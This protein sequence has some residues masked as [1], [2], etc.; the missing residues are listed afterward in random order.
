[1]TSPFLFR[2][3]VR[4]SLCPATRWGRSRVSVAGRMQRV[5][6][7]GLAQPQEW[8]LS[9]GARPPVCLQP[10]LPL[11]PPALPLAAQRRGRRRLAPRGRSGSRHHT[12][13]CRV[14]H[15]PNWRLATRRH[16]HELRRARQC[17]RPLTSRRGPRGPRRTTL[18]SLRLRSSPAPA[19]PGPAVPRCA[20]RPSAPARR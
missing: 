17:A 13:A 2:N 14:L 9:K 5:P 10:R 1:M 19:R 6:R 12:S 15:V 16:G 18:S 11:L 4:S 8:G 7:L 20:R 3:W